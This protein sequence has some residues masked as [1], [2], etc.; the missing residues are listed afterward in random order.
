MV[1]QQDVFQVEMDLQLALID[2]VQRQERHASTAIQDQQ[3]AKLP[4]V[5]QAAFNS[6][7]KQHDPPC[8]ANTRVELL[9]MIFGWIDNPG[10]QHI[11]WLSG[12]AGTGKTTI[13][14]TVAQKHGHFTVSF[15]FSRGGGD[16]GRARKIFTSIAV[17]LADRSPILRRYICDAIEECS[18]ISSLSLHDQWRYLILTPL[19]RLEKSFRGLS[20]LLVI[21]ALDEC[22]DENDIKAIINLVAE[23]RSLGTIQFR[24]FI[25]SRPDI[26]IRHGFYHVDNEN[27]RDFVL[28]DIPRTTIGNDITHFLEHNF[29]TIRRERCLPATWPGKEAIQ[30]LVQMSGGLFIWAATACRFVREGK[31]FARKRLETIMQGGYSGSA[32]LQTLDNIYLTVL[33]NSVSAEFDEA[34]REDMFET[35]ELILGSL[36]ILSSPLTAKSLAFLL[37]L[38][39]E[40]INES[41]EDLHAILD[42]PGAEHRESPIRLHHPSFRDFLLSKERCHNTN[43]W[44]DEAK[45][46]RLLVHKCI[47]LMSCTL[48]KDIC[49]L[50]HAGTDVSAIDPSRVRHYIPEEVQY[51]CSYWIHHLEKSDVEPADDDFVHTFLQGH[52]LHWLEALSL[53]GRISEGVL[54]ILS[55]ECRTKSSKSPSLYAFLH[56]AKRFALA[57]RSTIEKAPLQTYCSA[58]VFIPSAS[59]IRKHFENEAP[60]W[61]VGKP[62]TSI[63]WGASL[64]ILEGHSDWVRAIALSPDGKVLASGAADKTTRLWDTESGAIL[65]TLEGHSNYVYGVAFSS[66]GTL[67][68]GSSDKTIRLWNS[69]SGA[70]LKVL[71]GHTLGVRAVAFAPEASI[72]ASGSSDN[73]IRLWD[74]N[75]GQTIRVLHEHTEWVYAIAFSLDGLLSSASADCTV[76]IWDPHSGKVLHKIEGYGSAVRSVAFSP[77]GK[78]VASVSSDKTV[79][80]WHNDSGVTMLHALEGHTDWVY[81]VAFSPDGT[82]V[83]SASADRTIKIWDAKTQNEVQT[84]DGHNDWIFAV[85]FSPDGRLLASAG[86]D[87]SIRLWDMTSVTSATLEGHPTSI[88]AVVFSSDGKMLASAADDD[89]TIRLWDSD[90]GI[91]RLILRGHSDWIYSMAF[92]PN[93]NVLVSTSDD[94]TI[95]LWDTESGIPLRT[96]SGHA[97]SRGV[98]FSPDN[99][100]IASASDDKTI[101]LWDSRTE[102][103]QPLQTL[104]GHSCPVRAV[105]FSSSGIVLASASEDK[106]I[107]LWDCAD[108]QGVRLLQTLHGHQTSIRTVAFSPQDDEQLLASTSADG[109]IKIWKISTGAVLQHLQ[110][111]DIYISSIAFSAMGPYLQTNM[112]LLR[113][114][115]YSPSAARNASDESCKSLAVDGATAEAPPMFLQ[116][117]W[118]TKDG[119]RL[120][121][122]PPQYRATCSA[123][124]E[125]RFGL[126]HSSGLVSFLELK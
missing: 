74:V 108:L 50:G 58:L 100:L 12:L 53:I 8:L 13:A 85:A 35:L 118:I 25:S 45:T 90:S 120:L 33:K 18:N 66:D 3:L 105:A 95:R 68:S 97:C 67:A 26:P 46:Q 70:L 93:S 113:I 83:A 52:F 40:A 22:D 114:D 73:T 84:L 41:L 75:S 43:F 42:I 99:R 23:A 34:E 116:G 6:L 10:V 39:E 27:H 32:P 30:Q 119:K 15:F 92:S 71:E 96:L 87:Q 21:D 94:K 115:C 80:L 81:G 76:C 79:W 63:G 123:F 77:D 37:K 121:W 122:L 14:G 82:L 91:N 4:N 20:L 16:T 59:I 78:Q 124:H 29:D 38:E 61:I 19:S 47:E 110:I 69:R 11:F 107:R 64:Q 57:N 9:R 89:N 126:G 86:A 109:V 56:D 112:G 98:I 65:H 44:V 36:V 7:E 17:Q 60:E 2:I 5:P 101:K 111:Y 49:D 28:H 24:V 103:D 31:R 125:N 48:R 88:H 106:T 54:A 62:K 55:F 51:A 72:L 1:K 117:S 104:E 102:A